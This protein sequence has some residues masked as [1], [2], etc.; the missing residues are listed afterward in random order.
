MNIWDPFDPVVYFLHTILGTTGVIA[1]V[2]A[3]SAIKGSKFHIRAGWIFS[4]LVLVAAFT[5]MMFSATRLSPPAIVSSL[6]VIGLVLGAILALRPRN[7][8]VRWG[9]RLAVA[10]LGIAFLAQFVGALLPFLDWLGLLPP[11]PPSVN[12]PVLTTAGY[13]SGVAFVGVYALIILAFLVSDFRFLRLKGGERQ[14]QGF[15]R[16]LSR[17]AFAFAIAVHAP[18]VSLAGNF[19]LAS[20]AAAN[21][22]FFYGPFVVYP[23]IMYLLRNHR[24]LSPVQSAV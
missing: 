20:S 1:A 12:L 8:G 4:A 14:A 13:I 7:T 2:V 24:L 6:F 23:I 3:L 15:R 11:P 19:G 18:I 16:H 10:L 5:A 17:M 9:E 22:G 21:F